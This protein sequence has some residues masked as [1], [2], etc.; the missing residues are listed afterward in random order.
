MQHSPTAAM[1]SIS[2]LLNHAPNSPELNAMITR[3]GESYSSM[4][5]I[6]ESKR[7]KKSSSDWL[8]SDNA[9]IQHLSEKCDVRV[10]PF[11]Q[12]LQKYKLLEVAL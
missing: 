6:H 11:C 7:L 3:F 5:M 9:L 2:L 4:S 10:F 1:L 8:N 12:V